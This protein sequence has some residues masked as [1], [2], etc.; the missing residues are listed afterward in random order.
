MLMVLVQEL[1]ETKTNWK[2]K[3]RLRDE[4]AHR[5]RLKISANE[6]SPIEYKNSRSDSKKREIL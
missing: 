5:L 2:H 4:A 3:W 6:E 1:K